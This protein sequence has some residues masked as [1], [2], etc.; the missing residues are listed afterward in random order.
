MANTNEGKNIKKGVAVTMLAGFLWGFSGT[1]SQ[2]LF[3]NYGMGPVDLVAY[4][5]LLSGLILTAIAL[6]RF[7]EPLFTMLKSKRDVITL[8]LFAIAGLLF[9]QLSYLVTI[10]YTNS[11]TATIL[12]YIGPVLVMVVCC[13]L[14]RRLPQKKE[15]LAVLLVILGTFLIATQGNIHALAISRAGLIWGL[16]S[17]VALVTYTMIPSRL[18]ANYGTTPV[19]GCGMLIAGIALVLFGGALR[20]PLNTEPRFQLF[21]WIIII[22]GTVLPY[23]LYLLG[24]KWCGAVKASMIASIEPVSATVWMV[25]WLGEPFY[26]IE[27]LGFL[28]IFVTVFL[29]AKKVT[30]N[31]QPAHNEPKYS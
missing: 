9:N 8:L 5:E 25:V 7:R 4:R 29:L 11:G 15:I 3:D 20:Q 27:A 26:P 17:A 1:C 12:Q 21:F 24:V 23:T 22:L 18:I 13:F 14:A 19:I 16:S 6:I 10:S 31:A 28:C 30:P 2:F